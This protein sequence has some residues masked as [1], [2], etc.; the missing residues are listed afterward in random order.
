M[1]LL[2]VSTGLG[3]AQ[4]LTNNTPDS[5]SE[6][7]KTIYKALVWASVVVAKERGYSPNVTEVSWFCPAE[8]VALAVGI[9]PA[10]LYRRLPEL[11]ALGLVAVRGHYATLNGCTRSDGSVWTVRLTP[12]SGSAARVGYDYLKRSYRCLG[13]DIESNKTAWQQVRESKQQERQEGINIGQVLRW[14]LPPTE[15]TPVTVDCRKVDLETIFDV[16][17]APKEDRAA[18]VFQAA[19]AMSMVLND[20]GSERFYCALLWGLLRV[21]DRGA[22]NFFESLYLMVRRAQTDSI[23]GFARCEAALFVS[24]VKAAPWYEEVMRGPPTRVTK[25]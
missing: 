1:P 9:H 13:A 18:M 2:E 15:R 11:T 24:R 6:T 23:E 14:T 10:T 3:V 7:A 5:L 21:R 20:S 8:A 12:R 25:A 16:P 17:H 22:G 4:E 19:V